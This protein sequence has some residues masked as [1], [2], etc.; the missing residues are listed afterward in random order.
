LRSAVFG[1]ICGSI[2]QT[3]VEIEILLDESIE[4]SRSLT[5]ELSFLISHEGG[6]EEGL[7]WLARWMADK[8]GLIVELSMEGPLPPLLEDVKMLLF[9]S[10]RELLFN[11][12]KHTHARTVEMNLRQIKN[13]TLQISVSD[14]EPKF[15]PAALR[16]SGPSAGVQAVQHPR[17][18][19]PARGR[20]EIDST[21][22]CGSWVIFIAPLSGVAVF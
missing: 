4:A 22:G 12:V 5:A 16:R 21:L 17:A 3:A 7:Q 2:A 10:V 9:E 19:E 11:A 20:V 18:A 14:S 15:E 1:R 13:E 6:F 8:H